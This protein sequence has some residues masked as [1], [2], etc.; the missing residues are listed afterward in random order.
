MTQKP[1][2][3]DVCPIGHS[4]KIRMMAV[5]TPRPSGKRRLREELMTGPYLC[6]RVSWYV[7]L[8]TIRYETIPRPGRDVAQIAQR[9]ACMLQPLNRTATIGSR[10]SRQ[11]P[12][13]CASLRTDNTARRHEHCP[14]PQEI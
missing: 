6:A 2:D 7:S 13:S 11:R 5:I 1:L 4:V 14:S 9:W 10:W 8:S 3:V 12:G